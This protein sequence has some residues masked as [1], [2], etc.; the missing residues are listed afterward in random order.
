MPSKNRIPQGK[1]RF[2]LSDCKNLQMKVFLTILF[3]GFILPAFSQLTIYSEQG[4]S[5]VSATC[6]TGTIFKGAAIPGNLDND[7]SSILLQQ[8]FM[9]TLAENEDGTG[10][11]YTFVAAVSN[12]SV[13]IN[14]FLNNKVSFIRVLPF[15]NT[16][17]KGVGNTNNN[18]IEPINV[19]WFYDWGALD[20]SLP[21]R[22]Y[23]LQ[24]WGK[25][26]AS[27]PANIANYIAKPD[28]THLLSFNEPDNTG[29]SNITVAEAI[30][31]HKLLAGTGLRLGSPAPTESQAF[32]W[33]RDFMAGTRAQNIKVDHIVIHWYDWGNWD[34][35]GNT[36]PSPT[37]VFNR[38]KAYVERVYSIY[39]KPIWIKEFNANRN[40][41]SAT[42]EGF[43]AL[44]LP[45]ME[46][47]PYIE[48]Y[49]YFFPPLLPPVDGSGTLTPIGLA[50]KNFNVSTPAIKK[51]IDNTELMGDSLNT[52]LEAE[53]A[54]R[55]GS[56]N[57]TCA[58]AS[59]GL[60]TQAV[61]GGTNRIAF[62]NIM[63]PETGNYNLEVSY[64]TTTNRNLTLRI[65]QAAAQVIPIQA[66]GP[67]CYE[68][69]TPGKHTIPV[70]LQAGANTIE[71]T[72]S[73]IIDFIE[74]KPSGTL[75]VTLLE[76]KGSVQAKSIELTWRTSQEKNSKYFDILKSTDGNHFTSIGKVNASGNSNTPQTYHFQDFSPATGNNFY[77]LKSVDLDGSISYSK[78]ISLKFETKSNGLSL[79]ASTTQGIKV[80]V[81][82][83]RNETATLSLFGVDG[84]LHYSGKVPLIEGINYFDIPVPFSRGSIGIVTLSAGSNRQNL[85]F[86]R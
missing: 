21:S 10:E 46:Q 16:L 31:L 22:E 78:S 62:H 24:A 79:I 52:K 40:T 18:W 57:I 51:N 60:M 53:N 25:Q 19:D 6:S 20:V 39:G 86:I 83:D 58:S 70:G 67:W 41:T 2:N 55:L 9:A 65:N 82:N 84:K 43:I 71:F 5:G 42:H 63:V 27:N 49:A 12:I 28:V 32:V 26:A 8:G 81:R 76:L 73:P 59:G 13:N 74:V 48:R 15:R 77:K 30:P 11:A 29:Q 34:A 75:P 44:A 14:P 66:S 37:S 45:W 54:T 36:A 85:K 35:T 7:I 56:N 33:L 38:F 68:G 69:G 1:G 80:A 47:Q 23:A 72:E 17:K 50:Y 4:Q 64:F 3:T 61:S